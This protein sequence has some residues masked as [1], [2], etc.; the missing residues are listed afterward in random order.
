MS[1]LVA[2]LICLPLTLTACAKDMFSPGRAK[3]GIDAISTKQGYPNLLVSRVKI[4]KDKLEAYAQHSQDP[5]ALT[6]AFWSPKDGVTFGGAVQIQGGGTAKDIAFPA[7]SINW[8][9]VP[10]IVKVVK[11]KT[12]SPIW[13]L[14]ID[15][16]LSGNTPSLWS[17]EIEG[18]DIAH[19]HPDGRLYSYATRKEREAMGAKFD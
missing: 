9:L 11:A 6:V 3:E 15:H 1:R 16:T 8:D 7:K 4:T 10:E 19:F 5:D 18:G 14:E 17:A 2:I 13:H 12:S